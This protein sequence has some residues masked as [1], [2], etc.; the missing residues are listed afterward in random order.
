VVLQAEVLYDFTAEPGN[1]EL[2]VRR[3][4]TVTVL[5]QTVGG[6]WIEAQ[7]SSGQ[8]GLVPEGYLQVSVD[9]LS[10]SLSFLS[11]AAIEDDDGEWDDDW[12]DQ[13]VGGYRGDDQTS[14]LRESSTL[15]I[16]VLNCAVD[17]CALIGFCSSSNQMGEVGPVWL[18]PL[19]PL[20]CVIADPKKESKLYGLKSFIEYQITPNT[21]NRPVN[22]R[23][24]HF[25]WLYERL[26]EKFGS[27]LPIPSLPDKQVTGRFEEDF[28]RMRME[29]LQ[30]WMTRMCR[31]PV[32]SQSEVFQLF[33]TY[34]D[35]KDWKA[36][37]RKA[38]KDETVG[39]M[40][41]SLLEPEAAE[42]DTAEVEQKCEH[43]SRFTKSMDDG[44]RELLN[45]GNTHW[46]RCTGP[47]PKE[48]ERI[49]RAF[50]N[51]ST[52][53]ISSRYP[54]EETL[55]D[56]LTAAGQTYEE[57]AEIVAQQPQKDLHF[58]LETN[59]EYK[60]LLGC[61]PEIMAV[62]KVLTHS[63]HNTTVLC[64]SNNYIL[65]SPPAEMNHFHSNRIYDYNRVMQ[66]YLQQQVTFY[67]QIA[68]KLRGALSRFATL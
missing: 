38:E 21:T 59:N 27:A 60:G 12:D 50:R 14:R 26:L 47:L 55:T 39:P 64:R 49:G 15:L 51:L 56:A 5:D 44:V 54:G 30:A 11:P 7:N 24:K 19:A 8:T 25:D 17:H 18:Y 57:I 34:R 23:Y 4:E 37:K 31:H 10:L 20:D 32:V 58:L 2:S 65:L 61:F 6:G 66:L 53:F 41:F 3:G 22:H 42:L 35:E 67:E 68:D 52:V 33:L 40:I 36:G 13:S 48:Y 29:Q 9:C 1:N 28:I 43:Y 16:T 45:V 63:T 46:K 62:H